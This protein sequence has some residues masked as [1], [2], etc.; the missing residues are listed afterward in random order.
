MTQQHFDY[1][2]ED[3]LFL[4]TLCNDLQSIPDHTKFNVKSQIMNV[5]ASAKQTACATCLVQ[6]YPSTT[7]NH[8]SHPIRPH[9][10][11]NTYSIKFAPSAIQTNVRNSILYTQPKF[12]IEVLVHQNQARTQHQDQLWPTTYSPDS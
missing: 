12:G 8:Y 1:D 10:N 3:R 5:I 9:F 2:N 7:L 11:I 6:L 4:L